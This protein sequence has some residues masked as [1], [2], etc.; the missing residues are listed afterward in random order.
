MIEITVYVADAVP[1][2]LRCKAHMADNVAKLMADTCANIVR[3]EYTSKD[4][5]RVAMS[6][7]NA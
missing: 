1:V 5:L 4:G 7:D 6:R 3:I 2:V